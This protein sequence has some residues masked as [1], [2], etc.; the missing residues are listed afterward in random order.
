MSFGR[1]KP[2]WCGSGKKFKKCHLGRDAEKSLNYQATRSQIRRA[3]EQNLC[4]HPQASPHICDAI[5]S[6]HTIQRS[7]VLRELVSTDNHV[8]TFHP[9][10]TK[11]TGSIL[12]QRVGWRKASTITG[13][14]GKHDAETF[15]PLETK[16][17]TGS[18][19]Q[20]F[21]LGYRALCHEYFAKR[22]AAAEYPIA[23]QLLD[24]GQ[25]LVRQ[26]EIQE[27][28]HWHNMGVRKGLEDLEREKIQMDRAL[29]ELNYCA[30]EAAVIEISGP[31]CIASS[32][33]MTP[34][35][36]LNG[37]SLQTLH[38][39]EI[40]IQWLSISRD[41]TE[42]GSVVVFTWATN[43]EKSAAFVD[44]LLKLN[45]TTLLA[46]LPQLLFFYLENT[47]FSDSW[48]SNLPTSKAKLV[49]ELA[50][51]PNPYYEDGVF[52]SEQ[53]TPWALLGI[54]THR[55]S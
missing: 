27:L 3:G 35:V 10:F 42:S 14:C 54:S 4:L 32:G 49:R 47:Y 31:L 7:R 16:P 43:D 8:L 44:S 48:W 12:P 5:I 51:N 11:P 37:Q 2:C 13:F 36:D 53:I 18:I 22:A 21:L 23:R 39:L 52:T 50:L 38:D 34:D 6:A 26:Q 20:C 41:V 30:C 24:R 17:F 33:T 55:S 15:A 46:I 9:A 28:L 19:E 45:E 25:P 1:N 29:I 40:P